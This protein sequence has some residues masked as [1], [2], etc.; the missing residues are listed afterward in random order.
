MRRGRRG[1]DGH[2]TGEIET[3]DRQSREQRDEGEAGV[4]GA[5]LAWDGVGERDV[6]AEGNRDRKIT[7]GEAV[8]QTRDG[9]GLEAGDGAQPLPLPQPGI[10]SQYQYTVLTRYAWTT[11]LVVLFLLIFWVPYL[12]VVY[13]LTFCRLVC[14]HFTTLMRLS[15]ILAILPIMNSVV[16]IFIY[17]GKDLDFRYTIYSLLFRCERPESY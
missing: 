3:R 15:Q 9:P 16:N 10:V 2:G 14:Q 13:S 8:E 4:S 6:A 1:L 7:F 11:S 17:V 5:R 12:V